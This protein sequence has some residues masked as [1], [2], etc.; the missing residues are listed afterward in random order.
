MQKRRAARRAQI[1]VL[2]PRMALP[3]LLLLPALGGACREAGDAEDRLVRQGRVAYETTCTACH[4]RDPGQSGVL[5]PALAGASLELLEAKVL[6]GAYPPGY[7]P[8]HPT[9]IMVALP[10]LESALPAIHAY[11][12]G[13]ASAAAPGQ[14]GEAQAPGADAGAGT[15]AGT[16]AGTGAGR[17][18]AEP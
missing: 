10:H 2:L 5:G 14:R 12:A 13:A 15:E 1:C 9:Q 6:R 4:A 16:E 11:L 3:A 18:P 17:G 7:T 8:K